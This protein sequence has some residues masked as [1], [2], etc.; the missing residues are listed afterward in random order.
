MLLV[1]WQRTVEVKY[2]WLVVP[3]D[4]YDKYRTHE[5]GSLVHWTM[6]CRDFRQLT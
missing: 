1:Y 4:K 3:C 6:P 2:H 5:N